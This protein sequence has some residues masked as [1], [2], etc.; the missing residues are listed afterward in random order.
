MKNFNFWFFLLV[1]L[2][3]S[4]VCCSENNLKQ[5]L[6][7]LTDYNGGDHEYKD[8]L[9]SGTRR[10]INTETIA[11]PIDQ[12]IPVSTRNNNNNNN[13]VTL[14]VRNENG[15]NLD[16]FRARDFDKITLVVAILPGFIYIIFVLIVLLV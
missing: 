13:N 4:S 14:V 6:L 11:S 12:T 15:Y 5:N 16:S 8:D 9:E 2:L 1:A 10:D 3:F 7:E